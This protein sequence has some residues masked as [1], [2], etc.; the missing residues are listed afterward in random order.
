[1]FLQKRTAKLLFSH[2]T[3]YSILYNIFL[4]CILLT[5]LLF[6]CH[7]SGQQRNLFVDCLFKFAFAILYINT[8]KYILTPMESVLNR[9]KKIYAYF[10]INLTAL[11]WY[12]NRLVLRCGRSLLQINE[13]LSSELSGSVITLLCSK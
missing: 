10:F 9:L 5:V 12:T 8:Y 2:F 4:Y 1:M 6:L 3:V 11:L 13:L 7:L